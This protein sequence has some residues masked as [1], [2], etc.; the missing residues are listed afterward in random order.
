MTTITTIT[1]M[2]FAVSRVV[3]VTELSRPGDR[4]KNCLAGPTV[5]SVPK[6]VKSLMRLAGN[7]RQTMQT[8]TV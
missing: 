7:K 3:T 2:W 8:K 1:I 6:S 5:G 4:V